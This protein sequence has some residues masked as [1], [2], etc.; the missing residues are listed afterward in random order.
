MIVHVLFLSFI[1]IYS[2][3]RPDQ[4]VEVAYYKVRLGSPSASAKLMG[5]GSMK[6]NASATKEKKQKRPSKI[7]EFTRTSKMQ[8]KKHPPKKDPQEIVKKDLS[9]DILVDK[10]LEPLPEGA[11]EQRFVGKETKDNP[12]ARITEPDSIVSMHNKTSDGEG[13]H[14]ISKFLGLGSPEGVE[15]IT[16]GYFNIVQRLIEANKRYP[17]SAKK[18]GQ[19]GR[20]KVKFTLNKKGMLTGPIEIIS[21]C[22]WSRL[23]RAARK[24]IKNSLPFPAIPAQIGR[25]QMTFTI[26]IVFRLL[27]S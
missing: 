15:D 19:E 2:G 16:A 21:P 23:N 13:G 3:I 22:I 11:E 6:N 9:E 14:G 17:L 8:I 24:T 4:K 5:D 12:L 18:Q 25:E 1:S 26:D 7:K 20:V 27:A 10:K